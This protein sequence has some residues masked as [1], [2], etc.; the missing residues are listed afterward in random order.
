MIH[1]PDHTHRADAQSRVPAMTSEA[2]IL[3]LLWDIDEMEGQSASQK[4]RIDIGTDK[5]ICTVWSK[6]TQN[7]VYSYVIIYYLLYYFPYKNCK[8]TLPYPIEI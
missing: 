6:S 7:I 1:M 4:K 8:P 2:D 3:E 5:G